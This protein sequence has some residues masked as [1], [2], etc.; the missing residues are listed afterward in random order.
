MGWGG[1]GMGDGGCAGLQ[2]QRILERDSGGPRVL[3]LHVLEG[4]IFLCRITRSRVEQLLRGTWG[5]AGIADRYFAL[6][7][8]WGD[9]RARVALERLPW[10]L[11]TALW[12]KADTARPG[13][14]ARSGASERAAFK[15]NFDAKR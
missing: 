15:L 8:A 5:R 10:A 7:D 4:G 13:D 2:E 6:I 1:G 12:A 3:E 9:A 11:R 14:V